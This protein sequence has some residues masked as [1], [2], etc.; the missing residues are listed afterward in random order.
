M[1][2]TV[3]V[4]LIPLSLLAGGCQALPAAGRLPTPSE[5][6]LVSFGPTGGEVPLVP[7]S[8]ISL[9]FDAEAR[10][11]GSAGCNAYGGDVRVGA[12]SINF[13]ALTSTLMACQDPRIME[14]ERRYL[15][16]LQSASSYQVVEQVLT[17][18]YPE[19]QL[20]FLAAP[21]E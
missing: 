6:R 21:H 5:W 15:D 10:A 18:H 13:A 12:S 1:V 7:G 3:A 11:G 8:I 19:G 16:A 2:R 17:I 9:S 14:Q 20:N 4:L